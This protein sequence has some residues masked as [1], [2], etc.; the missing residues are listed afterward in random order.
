MDLGLPDLVIA[1]CPFFQQG[2][3]G[4]GQSGFSA[5]AH[6]RSGRVACQA[7]DFVLFFGSQ[8]RQVKPCCQAWVVVNRCCLRV[9]DF[10]LCGGL[11]FDFHAWH[12][13][14]EDAGCRE[15]QGNRGQ[16]L[17]VCSHLLGA[18]CVLGA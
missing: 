13:L 7:S 12:A 9:A 5:D 8:C 16:W 14:R 18:M 15:K 2:P 1:F 4:C 17:T 3:V 10:R 11:Q 6:V